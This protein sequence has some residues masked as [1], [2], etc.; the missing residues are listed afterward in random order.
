MSEVL[1][2]PPAA[3]APIPAVRASPDML[4]ELLDGI[5]TD[6]AG[7][8]PDPSPRAAIAREVL[9]FVL[10]HMPH[11]TPWSAPA[12]R[13]MPMHIEMDDERAGSGPL[14]FADIA[15]LTTFIRGDLPPD[16]FARVALHESMH[17]VEALRCGAVEVALMECQTG[18]EIDRPSWHAV[19]A[20]PNIRLFRTPLNTTAPLHNWPLGQGVVADTF[21]NSIMRRL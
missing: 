9:E 15:T 21:V 10:A 19:L 16:L 17:I 3:T 14:G 8:P 7:R 5:A 20:D 1:Y 4:D 6:M 11:P 18:P 2:G 12:T 13:L